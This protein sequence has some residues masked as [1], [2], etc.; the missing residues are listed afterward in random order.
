[1]DSWSYRFKLWLVIKYFGW[2]QIPVIGFCR[3]R[4]IQLNSEQC[5]IEIRLNRRTKNHLKAMYF[6][7]LAVGAELSVAAVAF[8]DIVE[9][10]L[11]IDAL[12]KDFKIEFLKR[13][14]GDVHFICNEVAKVSEFMQKAEKTNERM[15]ILIRGHAIVP[16][17][18]QEPIAHYQLTLSVKNRAKLS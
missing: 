11:K 1:M 12:F 15:E 14:D 17:R 18:S 3:P 10:Q 7:A 6:G 4:F 16:S 13:A 9:K 2:F 5:I 8:K